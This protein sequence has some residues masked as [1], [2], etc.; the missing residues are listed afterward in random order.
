[1]LFLKAK[2]WLHLSRRSR[3]SD[4]SQSSTPSLVT[5][6][7]T[8]GA[9]STHQLSHAMLWSAVKGL[10]HSDHCSI[11]IQWT[12]STE[13]GSSVLNWETRLISITDIGRSPPLKPLCISH[14]DNAFSWK[15][16]PSCCLIM[17][18]VIHGWILDGYFI[19]LPL[20]ISHTLCE[21]CQ[22][23]IGLFWPYLHFNAYFI[24]GLYL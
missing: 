14:F 2:Y 16:L 1:M 3:M 10:Y 8:T 19:T 7:S 6:H 18:I 9:S 20:S 23:Q 15:T 4:V 13:I 11:S 21:H 24:I 12:H 5:P 17:A 22:C